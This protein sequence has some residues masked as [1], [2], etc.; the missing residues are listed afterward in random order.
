MALALA[1][2]EKLLPQAA[3]TRRRADSLSPRRRR[4]ALPQHAG[5]GVAAAD[6]ALALSGSGAPLDVDL[7]GKARCRDAPARAPACRS[8][9][10]A[11]SPSR[12]RAPASVYLSRS[13]RPACRTAR[14][15]PRLQGMSIKRSLFHPRRQAPPTSPTCTRTTRSWWWSREAW[16]TPP[17]Q[18]AAGRHAAGGAGARHDRPFG[19]PGC[20]ELRLAEGPDPAD[21][22]RRARR[23]LRRRF[24]PERERQDALQAGLCGAGRDARH[25]RAAGRR[26]SRT[27]MR[28][29]TTPAARPARWR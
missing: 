19:G 1:A 9:K 17:A 22:H 29:P 6:G 13:R 7:D 5:T 28:P 24:R 15:R 21:L 25:L 12:T 26:R 14:N 20:D 23:P 27:C 11:A 16:T 8:A 10:G 3:L 4:H 2:E 18:G